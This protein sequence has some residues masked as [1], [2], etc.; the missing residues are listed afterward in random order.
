M[1][2]NMSCT[3]SQSNCEWKECKL[4]EVG[5]VVTGKTPSKDNPE[6]WGSD[7]LFITPSDYG[8]Y[9]KKANESI[10]MLSMIGV[11]RQNNKLLPPNSVLVTCIGSD[12]GKS[13]VN[14]VPCITNQQINAIVP[15]NKIVDS[16]FVYY[17]TKDLYDI[18]RNLGA[19]G[20]AVPILNKTDFENIDILLPPLPE[21]KAIASVLSSL[22]DKIDLLHRQN[23]TLEA[24]AETLF[25]Q[26]FVEEA[27]EGWEN[28]SLEQHTDVFRG[29]SYKGSGL[30]ENGLGVPM[31]NLN[32]VY[33]GGG[34]KFEGIKYY[35]GDY[36]EKHIAFP[37]DIIVTNTEQ[38]HEFKL[39][40]FPAII[41]SSFGEIGIF[42]QHIYK[43]IPKD[44]TYISKEFIYYLLMVPSVREQIIAATNGSTVN[45]L[46]IDGLKRPEFKLPPEKRI[47]EFTL[48]ALKYWDKKEN[49]CI[50]IRTLEKLRDNLLPKLMSG[51]VRVEI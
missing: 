42:S 22:D 24:M 40:G 13:V 44:K 23:K 20:T 50:Q 6:D 45:M 31:H 36:K 7:V 26:W 25:R 14:T 5:K 28:A 8:K 4:G 2:K 47:K 19:D 34:Y 17:L 11:K 16:D 21:Q 1:G 35:C 18:L 15:Y 38:G 33:E 48:I 41:P 12:M 39:I 27:D 10:R 49:N 43:I 9:G 51:E 3:M 46:S 29:L 32:S 30:T 37:G